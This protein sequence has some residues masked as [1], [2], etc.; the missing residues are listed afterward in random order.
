MAL[1]HPTLTAQKLAATLRSNK[2]PIIGRIKD[3][4]VLLDMR[5]AEHLDELIADLQDLDFNP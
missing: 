1:A 2:T 4:Q 5:G 3:D